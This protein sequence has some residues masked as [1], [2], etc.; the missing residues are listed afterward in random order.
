[1]ILDN[2]LFWA[3]FGVGALAAF[4]FARA[5]WHVARP[6][7]RDRSDGIVRG[8]L[9]HYFHKIHAGSAAS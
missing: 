6:D 8:G 7:D 2:P 5:V 1:V 4:F 3:L 9:G